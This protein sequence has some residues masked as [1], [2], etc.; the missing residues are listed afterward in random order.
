MVCALNV[1]ISVP[2]QEAVLSGLA[3]GEK[4]PV[5]VGLQIPASMETAVFTGSPST[6]GGDGKEVA[7]FVTATVPTGLLLKDGATTGLS[8]VFEKVTPFGAG[9][10]PP[11]VDAVVLLKV[12]R[13]QYWFVDVTVWPRLVTR[14]VAHAKAVIAFSVLDRNGVQL[15]GGEVETPGMKGVEFKP[16]SYARY[17]QGLGQA[18][19]Q[20]FGLA[21]QAGIEEMVSN[22]GVARLWGAGGRREP[23]DQPGAESA[24][25]CSSSVANI[26]VLELMGAGL[27]RDE[28]STLTSRLRSELFRSGC[29]TILER[30]EMNEILAEQAF[31]QSGCTSTQCMVEAGRLLSVRYMVG[32]NIGRVGPLHSLDLRMIDVESGIITATASQD[33]SGGI[34]KVVTEGLRRC[35]AALTTG[36]VAQ[37]GKRSQ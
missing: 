21:L 35:A 3:T 22:A 31:Q 28:L 25:V 13:F 27:N 26:A 2:A 4:K 17:E 12:A 34:E 5:H 23:A 8:Q 16:S 20:A 32:G 29:Y 6:P 36:V 7:G 10:F 37:A 24:A 30:A 15:W 14:W 1:N 11:G 18:A 19:A 33:V 9:S